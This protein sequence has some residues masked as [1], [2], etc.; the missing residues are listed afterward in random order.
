M[1]APGARADSALQPV[2][3]RRENLDRDGAIEARIAGFVDLAHP[4]GAEWRKNLVRTETSA[5][6][7]AHGLRLM[8]QGGVTDRL[9][10]YI[11][12]EP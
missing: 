1:Y 2:E 5:G 11:S 7:K 12:L 3:R 10:Q 8:A 9:Q 6:G 4:P